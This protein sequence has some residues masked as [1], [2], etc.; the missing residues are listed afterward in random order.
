MIQCLPRLCIDIVIREELRVI[1]YFVVHL[2]LELPPPERPGRKRGSLDHAAKQTY[3][4]L[5]RNCS[6]ELYDNVYGSY[7]NKL[8]MVIKNEGHYD[9]Q[10]I[11][12]MNEPKECY[13]LR[14]TVDKNGSPATMRRNQLSTGGRNVGR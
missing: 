10:L 1:L 4:R 6:L 9:S 13:T 14:F 5:C 3:L 11:Y 2:Q 12:Q 8:Y 7:K